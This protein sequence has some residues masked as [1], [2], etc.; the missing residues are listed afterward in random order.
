MTTMTTTDR[1]V[2]TALTH[3]RR[4]DRRLEPGDGVVVFTADECRH[5]IVRSATDAAATVKV[6]GGETLGPLPVDWE[7]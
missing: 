5:G 4:R 7:A 2:P 1:V 6:A 3:L